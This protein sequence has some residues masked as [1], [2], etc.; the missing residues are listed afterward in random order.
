[1]PDIERRIM[2]GCSQFAR[3][4]KVTIQNTAHC[5]ANRLVEIVSLHQ[6]R[7]KS[8]DGA[9]LEVPGAFEDF[10]QQREDRRRVAFLAGRLSGSQT[11]FA[12]RHRQTSHRVQYHQYILALIAEVLCY[13]Q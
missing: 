5:V 3:K 8:R 7:E 1:M 2:A 10:G 4:Y 9:L 12:L 6:Y 11:D 13:R